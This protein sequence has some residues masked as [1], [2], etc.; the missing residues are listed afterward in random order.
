MAPHLVHIGWAKAGSSI[1]QDWFAAHPQIAFARTGILGVRRVFDLANGKAPD[2]AAIRLR[3]TSEE[4][5][6]TPHATAGAGTLAPMASS[7]GMAPEGVCETLRDLFPGAW[8]LIV[9]RG[10]REVLISS[11]SQAVKLG[12][13][14]YFPGWDP[15]Y[16]AEGRPGFGKWDYPRVIRCYEAAFPGR[17]IVLPYELL[18]DDPGAFLGALEQV[19]QLDHRPLPPGIANPSLS[20]VELAWYPFFSRFIRYAPIPAALKRPLLRGYLRAVS[21]GRLRGL[22]R[23]CQRARPRRLPGADTIN[24]A[25]LATLSSQPDWLRDREAY[26]KYAAFYAADAQPVPAGPPPP[27]AA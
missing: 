13:M 12:T 16:C 11:Y 20:P 25:V 18:R 1:L 27:A 17:V 4:S 9:T 5:L 3:V 19:F 14:G 8:I 21:R 2:P 26:G 15:D 22:A 6:A 7:P 10:Y 23:A 24:D